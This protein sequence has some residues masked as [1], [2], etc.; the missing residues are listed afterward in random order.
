MVSGS[1]VWF[2]LQ[3]PVTPSC[4]ETIR[5][6]LASP[7]LLGS[8]ATRLFLSSQFSSVCSFQSSMHASCSLRENHLLSVSLSHCF[9]DRLGYVALLWCPPY[10][11]Q[12][13]PHSPFFRR[14]RLTSTGLERWRQ[15]SPL[16]LMGISFQ[17][18]DCHISINVCPP[19][20]MLC[21]L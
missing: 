6:H 15:L 17:V 1:S 8:I 7:R 9:S 13:T 4:L 11:R 3:V 19:P 14:S 12:N 5:R 16:P 10:W 2:L 18:A 20:L 21:F